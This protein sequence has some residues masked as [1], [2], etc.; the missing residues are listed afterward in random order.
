[1]T[2]R[3]VK[4]IDELDLAQGQIAYYSLQVSSNPELALPFTV[5]TG[6][7]PGKTLCVTSGIHGTEYSPIQAVIEFTAQIDVSDLEGSIILFPVVN[8]PAFQS[9]SIFNSPVDGLNLNR[10]FPGREKGSLTEAIA[11]ALNQQVVSKV[12]YLIDLHSGEI[13]EDLFPFALYHETGDVV[14]DSQSGLLA[15]SFGVGLVAKTGTSEDEGWSDKGALYAV[16]AESGVPAIIAEAGSGEADSKSVSTLITGLTNVA[17]ALKMI[18]EQRQ[19]DPSSGQPRFLHRLLPRKAEFSG[20]FCPTH[21]VG[22]RVHQGDI[23]GH[24]TDVFTMNKSEVS[25]PAAGVIIVQLKS[26]LADVGDT[27]VEIGVL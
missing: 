24:L 5:A 14:L 10:V 21:T 9:K 20:L 16:A 6:K 27:L 12:D 4:S 19:R 26:I 18:G 13:T 11:H 1:M 15:T 3:L 25:S 8:L 22:D 17:R 23:I 7:K 2:R